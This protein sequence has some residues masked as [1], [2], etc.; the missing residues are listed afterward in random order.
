MHVMV[1]SHVVRKASCK[2]LA[3]F[4][5]FEVEVWDVTPFSLVYFHRY[6]R[7]VVLSSSVRKT[8]WPHLPL[9]WKEDVPPKFW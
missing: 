8:K 3:H 7:N 9:R 5:R 2:L 1:S 6:L 4:V